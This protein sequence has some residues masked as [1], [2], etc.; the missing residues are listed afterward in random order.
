MIPTKIKNFLASVGLLSGTIIGAGVFSL[1]YLFKFSGFSVG[2]AYLGLAAAA[3]IL[4]YGMYAEIISATPGEHRFVGYARIYLGKWA[5]WVGILMTIVQGVLVLTIYLILSESFANLFFPLA[6]GT[7]K[8]IIFWFFAS[9]SILLGIKKIARLELL[10]TFGMIGIFLLLMVFGIKNIGAISL[11]SFAPVW[12]NLFLPFSA[13]LFALSGRAA[14]PDIVR[15]GAPVKKVIFWGIAISAVIYAIFAISTVATSALVTPDAVTGLKLSLPLMMTKL[16]GVL[17]ILALISSYIAIGHDTDK[18][19]EFDFNFPWWIRFFLVMFGPLILYFAGLNDFLSAVGWAGGI[20]IS[21][22]SIFI[23]WMW[24]KMKGK[25]F[26][27]RAGAL[28]LFFAA[29]LIYEIIK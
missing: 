1:P 11:S 23:V 25:K 4:L 26:S 10:I 5:G 16:L 3:C 29:A 15:S 12:G 22:E 7:T 2:L 14:I 9:A 28:I 24:L 17:G 21:L 19:L 6:A 18:S 20:F 8:I 27:W 13:V